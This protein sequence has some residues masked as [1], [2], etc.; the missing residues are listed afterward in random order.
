MAE[1]VDSAVGRDAY[2][3]K[4]GGLFG[5]EAAVVGK[6]VDASAV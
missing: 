4:E 5:G 3:G 6:R 1:T 2:E